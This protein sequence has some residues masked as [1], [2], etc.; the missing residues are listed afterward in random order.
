MARQPS[1]HDMPQDVDPAAYIMHHVRDGYDWEVPGRAGFA[2]HFDLRNVVG[3]WVVDLG[4]FQLD[5][6]P[7]KLTVMVWLSALVLILVLLAGTR[8]RGAVPKGRLQ[9]MVEMLFLFVR[10]EI[11]VKNIGHDGHRYT[12]YLATCFFFILTMNLLGLIPYSGTATGNLNVTFILAISTFVV[13][14][15][16]GMRAQGVVGYWSHLVPGGVPLALYPLMIP[17][18][19]IG[20]FTKP[21][22][23]M[24]RLFANMLAGHI[25]IFFLLG[26]IFFMKTIYVAPMSVALAFAIYF[27]ELFI[28]FLQA[29][30]FTMLSALFIG[31]ASHAH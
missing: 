7:T 3:N 30:I 21:F 8:K 18:E 31:M 15:I 13:T 17:L 22:A 24:M 9:N 4:A 19:I 5:L 10:D 28:A 25:V 12:P 11:A 6:T 14:Q 26:L 16:A 1:T 27:L 23:L 20:L 2:D 29:Y